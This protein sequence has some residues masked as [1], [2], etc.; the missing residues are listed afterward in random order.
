ML[1]REWGFRPAT[2]ETVRRGLEH[3]WE[4][5]LEGFHPCVRHA[6]QRVVGLH[7]HGVFYFVEIQ[8]SNRGP[9]RGV[10]GATEPSLD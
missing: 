2:A 7:V 9:Q 10:A 6:G 4:L 1:G 5:S 3:R 8:T